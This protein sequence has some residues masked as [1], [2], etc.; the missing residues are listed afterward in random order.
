[1]ADWDHQ[2]FS[3]PAPQKLFALFTPVC[4]LRECKQFADAHLTD[5]RPKSRSAQPKLRFDRGGSLAVRPC[6]VKNDVR[7]E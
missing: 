6:G 1:V 7:I 2:R 4:G 5:G 3:D